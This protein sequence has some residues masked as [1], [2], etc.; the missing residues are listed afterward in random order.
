MIAATETLVLPVLP[1]QRGEVTPLTEK[2]TR[3]LFDGLPIKAIWVISPSLKRGSR[4]RIANSLEEYDEL[5][6]C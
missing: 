2:F 1:L 6:L 4:T 3:V 5:D